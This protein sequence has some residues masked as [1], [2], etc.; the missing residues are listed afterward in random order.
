MLRL[1]SSQHLPVSPLPYPLPD[2]FDTYGT[3]IYVVNG[4][5]LHHG[6]ILCSVLWMHQDDVV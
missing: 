4:W 6:F 1:P 5:N 3:Y 2:V